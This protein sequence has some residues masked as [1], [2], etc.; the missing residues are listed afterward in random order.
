MGISNC[1]NGKTFLNRSKQFAN[2]F[3]QWTHGCYDKFIPE[4]FQHAPLLARQRMLDALLK[5]DG[6]YRKHEWQYCTV[7]KRLAESVER[8]AFGLGYTTCIR[9]EKDER[10]STL[11]TNYS[12][13]IHRQECRTVLPKAYKHPKTGKHY[14]DNWSRKHYEGVVYCATVP[15]GLLHVRGNKTTS[16]FWSGNSE[17]A[18]VDVRMTSGT[19]VGSDGRLRQRFKDLRTGEIRWLSP[20]D[21][22]GKSVKI[23]D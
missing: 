11:T 4:E 5:G 14:G 2:Y 3:A 19:K 23:P 8:L 1:D 20:R 16:G 7:S 17:R 22:V 18:G 9:I 12:V 6:R 13:R 15:G 10:P 21:L